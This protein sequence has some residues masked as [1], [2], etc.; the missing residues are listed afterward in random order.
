MLRSLNVL[1]TPLHPC[2]HTPLT[3]WFR[4]GGCNTDTNDRG[5]H[6]VCAQ[7][8][9]P[10]LEFLAERGNNLIDAVPEAGF[11]G[12][13][14]GDQWCIVATSWYQAYQAGMACPVMLESTHQATLQRV[15]ID[16]LMAHAVATEA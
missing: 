15:P 3:G 9:Q 10:F 12:L 8:T 7:V 1:G 16:A 6:T 14:P 13:R 2:S 5:L 4:D 11:K